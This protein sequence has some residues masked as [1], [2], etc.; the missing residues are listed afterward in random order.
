MGAEMALAFLPMITS[1]MQAGGQY[2]E[3]K[4]QME[5]AQYNAQVA[6]WQAQMVKQS[7]EF[8]MARIQRRKA[9]FMSAQAASYAKAGVKMEGSPIEV[10][11]D[12]A[13]EF[14]LDKLAEN[15][16]A[17]VQI[18]ALAS[19]SQAFTAQAKRYRFA[20]IY[21]P[22]MT[23]LTGAMNSGMNYGM[24]RPGTTKTT[25]VSGRGSSKMLSEPV[26]TSYGSGVRY[27]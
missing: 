1:A 11:A 5:A 25:P 26:I 8:A 20:S 14:E 12:T 21:Q 9:R 10:M 3:S 15:Y 22:S 16:N 24:S 2:S 7:A 27:A 13:T 6:A 17:Q 23:L 4:S 19:E 18:S